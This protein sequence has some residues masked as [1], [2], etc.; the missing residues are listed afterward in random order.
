M[1]YNTQALLGDQVSGYPAN[2]IAAIFDPYQCI[3]QAAAKLLLSGH[4]NLYLFF[5]SA[6]IAVFGK[7]E[8]VGRG[9]TKCF[10]AF[11]ESTVFGLRLIEFFLNKIS[12]F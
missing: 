12:K 4:E 2:P 1:R 3:F 10:Q 9:T 5:F 6:F 8:A 11:G 7:I